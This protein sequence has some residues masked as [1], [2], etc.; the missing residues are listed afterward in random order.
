MRMILRA[1]R[2]DRVNLTQWTLFHCKSWLSDLRALSIAYQ[3][4]S[5][6]NAFSLDLLP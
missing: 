2:Y 1:K 6:S 5:G 3:I 4:T